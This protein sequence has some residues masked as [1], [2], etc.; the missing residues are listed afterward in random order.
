[1]K[2]KLIPLLVVILMFASSSLRASNAEGLGLFLDFGQTKVINND[3]GREYY[4]SKIG[5]AR[6]DYQFTLGKSFSFLLF[7][8]E[9]SSKSELPENIKYEYYK[10][11]IF[12]AE[13]RAWMGPVFFA[14]HGGRFFLTWLESLSLGSYSDIKWSSGSG[15][16]LGIE[17]TSGWSLSWYNEKS[18]KIIF[19]NLPD[20]RV[21]GKALILGYRWD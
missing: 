21:D 14:I 11:G 17:S 18:E 5:G 15:W 2:K 8:K 12:G 4:S 1:M 19:D 3:T 13:F 16:G 9:F 10:T 7:G 20:Q 6:Y